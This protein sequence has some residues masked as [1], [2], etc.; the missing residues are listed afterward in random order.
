MHRRSFLA[1][2]GAAAVALT[3]CSS[4]DVN[5]VEMTDEFEFEPASITVGVDETV[6]WENAGSVGHTVTAY[7]DGIPEDAGY[8]A[9]GG[10]DS[11]DAARDSLD[12]GLIES[13]ET[14]EYTFETAGEHEYFCIPHE[15]SGMTGIVRVTARNF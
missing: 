2:A 11:E 6:T 10:F 3:G 9:S 1:L 7:R 12:D 13:G 14:Y 5:R 15:G 4:D 8:F